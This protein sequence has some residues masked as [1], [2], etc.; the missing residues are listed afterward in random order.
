MQSFKKG[1]WSWSVCLRYCC[2]GLWQFRAWKVETSDQK[3]NT[4]PAGLTLPSWND[5]VEGGFGIFWRITLRGWRWSS[6]RLKVVLGHIRGTICETGPNNASVVFA[7]RLLPR[8]VIKVIRAPQLFPLI[9]ASR[10]LSLLSWDGFA[11]ISI[12]LSTTV[13]CPLLSYFTYM[14][15]SK[16]LLYQAVENCCFLQISC[17]HF[18]KAGYHP[19]PSRLFGEHWRK[20]ST[21]R[22]HYCASVTDFVPFV[23]NLIRLICVPCKG[24]NKTPIPWTRWRTWASQTTI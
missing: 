14:P 16:R 7:V 22:C 10:S 2:W 24:C 21:L 15:F 18:W 8:C 12:S 3:K 11:F 5:A 9:A 19:L 1:Y 20:G 4:L 17:R 6:K 23:P 13:A